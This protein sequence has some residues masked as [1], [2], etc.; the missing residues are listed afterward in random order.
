MWIGFYLGLLKTFFVS[1][2]DEHDLIDACKIATDALRKTIPVQPVPESD[3][4]GW[5]TMCP[6]CR[7][8]LYDSAFL[9]EINRKSH[10]GFCIYCGQRFT[11]PSDRLGRWENIKK[12]EE[13][14]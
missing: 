2:Q 3:W 6:T 4:P 9:I 13:E 5:V 1:P 11:K 14:K 8:L 10:V 7:A 12:N